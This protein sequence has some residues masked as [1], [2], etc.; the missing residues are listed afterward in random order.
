MRQVLLGRYLWVLAILAIS[1]LACQIQEKP[2]VRQDGEEVAESE[3]DASTNINSISFISRPNAAPGRRLEEDIYVVGVDGT[4]LTRLTTDPE[5]D[6]EPVW[7][8]S[9]RSIAFL[10]HRDR[11]VEIYITEAD[12]TGLTRLTDTEDREECCLV[13]SR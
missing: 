2:A 4:G 6:F 9:G 3:S 12:G 5:N 1:F 10:S 8:P 13:V 11:N 7:S